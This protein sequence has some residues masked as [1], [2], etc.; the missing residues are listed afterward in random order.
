MAADSLPPGQRPA[1][2]PELL[3][4]IFWRDGKV[5]MID[6]RRLPDDEIW[7]AYDTWEDVAR[8]IA[9]LEVRGAPA[10]GCAGAFAV[11]LAVG[12]SSSAASPRQ[13]MRQIG[14]TRPP[15]GNPGAAV[16]PTGDA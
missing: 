4:P 8:A 1:E 14:E 13:H 5:V 9:D 15:P 7:N 10:I 3:S 16:P 12:S 6:Q 11:A 2:H